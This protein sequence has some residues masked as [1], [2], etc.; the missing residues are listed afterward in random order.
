MVDGWVARGN[1]V[2]SSNRDLSS[3]CIVHVNVFYSLVASL[4]LLSFIN[5]QDQVEYFAHSTRVKGM[6][7]IELQDRSVPIKH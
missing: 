4:W 7:V 6:R 5:A 1:H 2:P 3:E